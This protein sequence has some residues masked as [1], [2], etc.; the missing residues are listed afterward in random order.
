[1]FTLVIIC[2]KNSERIPKKLIKMVTW[3][4]GGGNGVYGMGWQLDFSVLIFLYI[5]IF[6]LPEYRT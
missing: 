2:I 4:G 3:G 1:M 6:E 5:L